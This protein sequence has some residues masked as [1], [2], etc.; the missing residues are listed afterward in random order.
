MSKSTRGF[1]LFVLF[2]F[3]K[4]LSGDVFAGTHKEADVPSLC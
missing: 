2:F 3:P 1:F 4:K